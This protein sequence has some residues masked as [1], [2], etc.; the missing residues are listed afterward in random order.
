[1][2]R[3]GRREKEQLVSMNSQTQPK[4]QDKVHLLGQLDYGRQLNLIG[5]FM[6]LML[7]FM[8]C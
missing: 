4:L 8:R 3:G 5:Y 6:L 2:A 7:F 1:M